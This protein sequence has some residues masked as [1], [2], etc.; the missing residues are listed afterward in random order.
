MAMDVR[1][2]VKYRDEIRKKQHKADAA[3][4]ALQNACAHNEH[5]VIDDTIEVYYEF[6]PNGTKTPK[7]RCKICGERN[8]PL[9]PPKVDE[10]EYALNTVRTAINYIKL[11][12]DPAD[13]AGDETIK[14]L[15]NVLN[16]HEDLLKIYTNLGKANEKD[17]KKNKHDKNAS[18]FALSM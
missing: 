3:Q 12:Y 11:R 9:T 10:L 13:H 17:K 14:F 15:A 7:L 8:I 6:G 4:R 16:N 5:L 1:Q 2:V 18:R